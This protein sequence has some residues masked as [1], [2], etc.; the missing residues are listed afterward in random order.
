[1]I[2]IRMYSFMLR[3]SVSVTS[4][5]ECSSLSSAS[6][7]EPVVSGYPLRSSEAVPLAVERAREEVRP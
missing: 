5:N 4:Q 1:M 3:D 6:L 2:P 7:P